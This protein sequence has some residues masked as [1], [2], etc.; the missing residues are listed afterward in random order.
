MKKQ[1]LFLFLFFPLALG[2]QQLAIQQTQ[3]P[4]QATFAQPFTAQVVLT[5]PQGQSV[6][7]E[8]DS[9]PPEFEVTHTQFQPL[10]D[11]TT[12]AVLT[13]VPFTL[14]ASTFT[15]TFSLAQD[16]QITA[17]AQATLTVNPVKLFDDNELREIRP[18]HKIFN[19][20]LWLCILLALFAA[21]CLVIFW[22]RRIKKGNTYRLSNPP[23]NRPAHVIA[24]AQLDALI[25][26]GLWENKQYKVFYMTL[27]D[28]LRTYLYRRFGLDVSADTSAELLRHIKTTASL[29]PFSQD[30]RIFLSSSDLVK[31]AKAVPTQQTRNRDITLLRNLIEQTTPQP[32][33]PNAHTEEHL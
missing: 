21:I 11:T 32:T 24:L 3:A 33:E 30:I 5:H 22:V 16:P 31:F 6:Q 25:D 20:A 29:L 28:I 23:D 18:P 14:Q 19:W 9:L 8:A 4:Q 2:A 27:C 7:L 26:S 10:D 1:L 12:Q 15:A 13:V 17:L